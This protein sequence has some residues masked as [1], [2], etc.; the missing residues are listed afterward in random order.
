MASEET[1]TVEIAADLYARVE[2]A[3]KNKDEFQDVASYVRFVLEQVLRE[4]APDDAYSEEE[5]EVIKKRLEDL[6][7]L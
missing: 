5:E 2:V 6:G 7:Y 3:I 4:E 1:K